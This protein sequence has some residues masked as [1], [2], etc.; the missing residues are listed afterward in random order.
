MRQP[1]PLWSAHSSD[2]LWAGSSL[3]W[4]SWFSFSADMI[5]CPLAFSVPTGHGHGV[6]GTRGYVVIREGVLCCRAQEAWGLGGPRC[7]PCVYKSILTGCL[8]ECRQQDGCWALAMLLHLAADVSYLLLPGA[9][10]KQ[11]SP[12]KA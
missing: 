11:R 10:W 6:R 9:P 4:T 8:I 2:G 5:S 12:K 1:L 7:P 3:L